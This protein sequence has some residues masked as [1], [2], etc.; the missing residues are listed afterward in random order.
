M[1]KGRGSADEKNLNSRSG[2]AMMV[3]VCV[4]RGDQN[5]VVIAL[6]CV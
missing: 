3:G 4:I 6:E 1:Y 5:T 2:M